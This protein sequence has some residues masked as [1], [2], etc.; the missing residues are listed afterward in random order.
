[1]RLPARPSVQVDAHAE[2]RVL[3]VLLTQAI[4][5]LR[6][7]RGAPGVREA[8]AWVC[9]PDDG[10]RRSFARACESL[11]IEVQDLRR[12]LGLRMHAPRRRTRRGLVRGPGR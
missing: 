4:A 7:G 9:A 5:A 11:G 1:M 12:R 10:G 6:R 8:R 3:L 2:P